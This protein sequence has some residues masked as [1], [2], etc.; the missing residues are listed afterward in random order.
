MFPI[1]T[2]NSICFG[3][4][5]LGGE[6]YISNTPLGWPEIS[7][8]ESISLLR[9]AFDKNIRH[10]D[11]SDF[12]G[13]GKSEVLLRNAFGEK[14]NQVYI[15]TK[16]GIKIAPMQ[17]SKSLQKDFSVTYIKN[18]VF[19]S[20][21]N[22]NRDYIDLYMLHGPNLSDISDDLLLLLEDLKRQGIIKSVG[23]SMRRS[24]FKA[25]YEYLSEIPHI[26]VL[27]F[28]YNAMNHE[29]IDYIKNL[30]NKKN[31]NMARSLFAH[32]LLL[33]TKGNFLFGPSDHRSDKVRHD[34][35]QAILKY[36]EIIRS[37]LNMS[38]LTA[39]LCLAIQNNKVDLPVIGFTKKEQI[40]EVLNTIKNIKVMQE[41][42]FND[43]ISIAKKTFTTNKEP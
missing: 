12:Y 10:F 33:K 14:I 25:S 23:V 43:I 41:N 24:K 15:S 18:Q 34:T 19:K 35:E 28:Q 13:R 39:S 42:T 30:K 31:I 11:T 22:L 1:N 2:K 29:D 32:G 27:Q 4:W 17:S 9:Y 21:E 40:D 16:G 20:L 3:T 5:G 8:H 38:P 6:N 26:D 37:Q 7:D 36:Q